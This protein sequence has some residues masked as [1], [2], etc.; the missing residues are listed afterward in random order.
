MKFTDVNKYIYIYI[1]MYNIIPWSS[2]GIVGI[3]ITLY[4]YRKC[5]LRYYYN[6]LKYIENAVARMI[7]IWLV[8]TKF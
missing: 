8:E 1:Y 2:M 6:M 5:N 7:L 3:I 4:H